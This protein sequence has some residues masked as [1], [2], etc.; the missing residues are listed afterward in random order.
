MLPS[1]LTN[2]PPGGRSSEPHRLLVVRRLLAP[3]HLN[4]VLAPQSNDRVLR[5]AFDR[6]NRDGH[7]LRSDGAEPILNR[8]LL[9]CR[10]VRLHRAI[11][12]Q[13]FGFDRPRVGRDEPAN[14]R[15]IME[16]AA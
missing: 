6:L 7:A 4:N 9:S 16:V 15:V 13:I 10:Q 5:T 8:S 1:D 12:C 14:R 2:D 3:C 11:Q